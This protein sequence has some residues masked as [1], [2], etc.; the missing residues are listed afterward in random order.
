MSAKTGRR[1]RFTLI[2]LL[3]VIVII[4]ILIGLLLPA[5]QQ[6]RAQA[7]ATSCTSQ[8][9]QFGMGTLSYREDHDTLMPPWLSS[10][11]ED[12]L[13]GPELLVCPQ[14]PSA[15]AAGGRPGGLLDELEQIDPLIEDEFEETDD[16][17]I[18]P[19]R[20]GTGADE[21]VEK[22]SYMYEFA[23]VE[24]SWWRGNT[25]WAR[26]QVQMA[27]GLGRDRDPARFSVVG[28]AWEPDL[29]PSARC[30]WHFDVL[31]GKKE[32]VLNTSFAG[33]FFKS[34]LIWEDG[35]Y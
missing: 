15:G 4:M 35:V 6:A 19:D 20:P 30:F 25:W 17:T 23:N 7:R 28:R 2:E 34:M 5:F 18:N 11:S 29:F 31:W 26:K 33:G 9:R 13:G 1:S 12:Y 32:L 24:C 27:D 22:C 21:D 14:D 3:V 16:I 8:M 10:I